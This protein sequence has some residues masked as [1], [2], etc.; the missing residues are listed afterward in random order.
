MDKEQMDEERELDGVGKLTER[1]LDPST[2]ERT[3]RALGGRRTMRR[4]VHG[5]AI[6]LLQLAI[7][8]PIL[9]PS[10][11]ITFTP[12]VFLGIIGVD[13]IGPC[14]GLR[15]RRLPVVLPIALLFDLPLASWIS[16]MC[17]LECC[18]LHPLARTAYSLLA[19]RP[20]SAKLE[21][22]NPSASDLEDSHPLSSQSRRAS[23]SSEGSRYREHASIWSALEGGDGSEVR[24]GDVRLLSLAWLLA[25]AD[26]GGVLP[27][28]QELP[29][30]AFLGAARLRQIE[31]AARRAIDR[32]GFV[33][34]LEALAKGTSILG[35]LGFWT[36]AFRRKR[37]VDGLLPIVSISYCWLEA[38]HPDREGRQLQ[39]LSRKLRSLYGGRGLLGAC[40]EYSFSDMGVFFDWGSGYQKDPALWRGWMA[41][42]ALYAMSDAELRRGLGGGDPERMAAER[43]A[44]ERTAAERHSYEALEE[45]SLYALSEES[46]S[47]MAGGDRMVAERRAYEASRTAFGRM[48]HHTMDLWYAHSAITVVLLTQ[49]PDELPAGFDQSRTYD[50]RGWTTFERCSA[51]L[52]KSY[53]LQVARWKLVIDVADEGGCSQRRLPTTPAR[54]AQLLAG[55]R[56]TNGADSATVLA[57]YAQTATAVLGTVEK[58]S[59]QGLPLV[60]GDPW[61]SPS[62][63]AEALNYC[64]RLRHLVLRGSRLG[65][66][67]VEELV[68]GLEGG[69]LPALEALHLG[70]NRFAARG[71]GACCALLRRGVAPQLQHLSLSFMPTLGDES[72][73][74]L[75]AALATGSLPHKL[76]VDVS[77][78]SLADE[79][80]KAIAAALPLAGPSCNIICWFNQFGLAGQSAMLAALDAKHGPAFAHGTKVMSLFTFPFSAALVRAA[81]LGGRRAAE[82]GRT[83]AC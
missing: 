78:C 63:L 37:N 66:D 25:L 56:F 52:A 43:M 71:T 9:I 21:A 61:C 28:R 79:G 40:R 42:T 65:D 8:I 70:A 73:A 76:A 13:T 11:M 34:A 83:L 15:W 31:A 50:T 44:A 69:A 19:R 6:L 4:L 75:A 68:A 1:G 27:R 22:P 48:L 16:A 55:C 49:L 72:A 2:A 81:A 14:D 57:L 26:R 39:L 62:R 77:F 20:S 38:A 45:G 60:R 33:T 12:F 51:E 47:T 58:L 82:S 18:I 64:Q 67:E 74:A 41:D 32:R 59:Y 46:L 17:I 80:A 24:C 7:M 35:F 3:A 53:Q 10:N 30:E 54:M 36:S 5:L 23:S 29:E